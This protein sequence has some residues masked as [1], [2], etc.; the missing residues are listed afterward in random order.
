MTALHPEERTAGRKR[1]QAELDAEFEGLIKSID[2][3]LESGVNDDT[4]PG[5][6]QE[7]MCA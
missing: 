6:P 5:V 7:A 4:E 3:L 1:T 2:K